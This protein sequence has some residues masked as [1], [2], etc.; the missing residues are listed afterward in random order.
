MKW[1]N[2]KVVSI[3]EVNDTVEVT[4]ELNLDDK[5]F[6]NTKKL[7]WLSVESPLVL[8]KLIEFDHL[9]KIK[10][11]D[12]D[13]EF[14]DAINEKTKFETMAYGDPAMRNL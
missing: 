1:G 3:K 14:M 4:A 7:N 11:I 2:A 12:E 6:K 5:D 13:T 10:Y 8:V 9:I